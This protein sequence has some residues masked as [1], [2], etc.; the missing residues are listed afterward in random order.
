MANVE[1]RTD[2]RE[3]AYEH[4]IDP[5]AHWGDTLTGAGEALG[6]VADIVSS[7]SGASMFADPPD[8][9]GNETAP[10]KKKKK[11]ETDLLKML[12]FLAIPLIFML[13]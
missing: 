5:N 8:P 7:A 4:G 11:G 9:E 6:G 12:P 10:N 3:T 2:A 1:Q 13:K